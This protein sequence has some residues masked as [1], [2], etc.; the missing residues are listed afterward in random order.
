MKQTLLFLAQLFFLY[1]IYQGSSYIVSFLDLPIPASV[2]GMIVLYILLSNG[3]VKLH[4]IEVAAS[5]LLKHLSLFF[6]PISV[7]LMDYGGLIQASGLQLLVMVAASTVI[8]LLV[9]GGLTQFLSTKKVQ[10][11]ENYHEQSHSH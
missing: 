6:V 9:T 8:G 11:E 2:F 10:K 1:L 5:F 4:Y 3:I 7:G